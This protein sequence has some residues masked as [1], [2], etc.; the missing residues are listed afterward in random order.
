M[1]FQMQRQMVTTSSVSVVLWSALPLE[2]M[3]AEQ[4]IE[5]AVNK[6]R[7]KVSVCLTLEALDSSPHLDEARG[8]AH[9]IPTTA[10]TNVMCLT[11]IHWAN[12]T[13]TRR[14]VSGGVLTLSGVALGRS[15]RT[16][17]TLPISSCEAEI[18]AIRSRCVEI[19]RLRNSLT[20]HHQ[21]LRMLTVQSW[22]L[23]GCWQSVKV[24]VQR[25]S[26]TS[27]RSP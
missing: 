1:S 20:T 19:L 2:T 4:N 11:D 8:V 16:Q 25:I 15:A 21:R 17:A 10:E 13:E 5:R 26:A 9:V 6:L 12:G 22:V 7:R 3:D 23:S 24:P 14:S 27:S 18:S